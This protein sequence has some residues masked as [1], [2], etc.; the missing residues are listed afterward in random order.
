MYRT[1]VGR[2]AV[3]LY[4]CSIYFTYLSLILFF[5]REMLWVYDIIPSFVKKKKKN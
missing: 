5:V 3:G 4:V 1:A 2:F